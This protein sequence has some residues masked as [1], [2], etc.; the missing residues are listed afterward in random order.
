MSPLFLL[1]SV[2]DRI[3]GYTVKEVRG[4]RR[5]LIIITTML[6]FLSLFLPFLSLSLSQVTEV[7]DF[8]LIAVEL[9]H[10]TTKAQHLHL[11]RQDSNNVFG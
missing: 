2:N 6:F 7:P 9:L 4:R 11:A 5:C 8:N 1:V 10:D 3:H